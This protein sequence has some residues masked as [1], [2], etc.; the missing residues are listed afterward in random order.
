MF[1]LLFCNKLLHIPQFT[2]YGIRI[3]ISSN[4]VTA[5]VI[6]CIQGLV[7]CYHSL[8]LTS[9]L[10]LHKQ[11]QTLRCGEEKWLPCVSE[12]P[13]GHLSDLYCTYGD[14]VKSSQFDKE[15]TQ[16]STEISRSH[17]C[18]TTW[19]F[20]SAATNVSVELFYFHLWN[21][22]LK[23]VFVFTINI[24]GCKVICKVLLKQ[25]ICEIT[26]TEPLTKVLQYV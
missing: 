12:A 15:V 5:C 20:V 22:P 16:V 19:S 26:I 21:L 7:V 1:Y 24:I 23:L 8:N 10:S 11:T 9:H 3:N 13:H 14:N 25:N 6:Y 18:Y 2:I 17:I 4:K